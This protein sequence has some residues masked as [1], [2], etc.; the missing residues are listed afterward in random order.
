MPDA[1]AIAAH[2]PPRADLVLVGHSHHDH[3]LDAPAVAL[4][5]GAPLL[6][7]LSTIRVRR[8]SG[9]DHDHLITVAG[10]EDL[11]FDGFSV[12]AIPSLHSRV[13]DRYLFA[14]I[15]AEPALPMP[16]AQY[17][18]GCRSPRHVSAADRPAPHRA[19]VAKIAQPRPRCLAVDRRG[20]TCVDAA[21]AP[22]AGGMAR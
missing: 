4:R 16:A 2:T 11:A 3:L 5:T 17:R 20:Q 18:E 14:E 13:G 6:G 22:L 21:L 15:A 8:A 9:L 7:S 10:G 1:A 12:R 19:Q